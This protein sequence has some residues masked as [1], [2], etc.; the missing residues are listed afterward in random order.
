MGTE[1]GTIGIKPLKLSLYFGTAA[2][3]KEFNGREIKVYITDFL[4]YLSGKLEATEITSK[5][6]LE[7]DRSDGGS[8]EAK[9]TNTITATY[10]DLFTNRKWP[11]DIRKG[12]QVF[13]FNVGDSDTYYWFSLGRD[14]KLR[15]CEKLR[16]EISDD[17][18]FI[19]E[20]TNDNT[21]YVEM[22]TLPDEEGNPVK[23]F[24]ISTAKSD[25]EEFRYL[26][27]IDAIANTLQINDD[28]DNMILMESKEKRIFLRN[29]DGCSLELNKKN[30]AL[31]A[32]DELTLKAGKLIVFDGPLLADQQDTK[33]KA[34]IKIADNIHFTANESFVITTPMLGIRGPKNE[35]T[36]EEEQ[37]NVTICG[38]LLTKMFAA[39][40][41]SMVKF[42]PSACG[43]NPCEE[44]DSEEANN[45]VESLVMRSIA[46]FG[47]ETNTLKSSGP[48]EGNRPEELKEE[49]ADGWGA[50]ELRDDYHFHDSNVPSTSASAYNGVEIDINTASCSETG[51]E[52]NSVDT[53]SGRHLAAWD[54]I[55]S[56]LDRNSVAIQNIREAIDRLAEV[57]LD[58]SDGSNP[59]KQS[60]YMDILN[61]IKQKTEYADKL[62]VEARVLG[63]NSFVKNG[64]TG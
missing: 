9:Q 56:A 32:V 21:W 6:G 4:P 3:D 26:I 60:S 53:E 59:E 38:T 42:D 54:Q 28:A 64:H 44:I 7:D 37:V 47:A 18:Q 62:G 27:R 19:K 30:A 46:M 1:S 40:C 51:N 48:D 45:N 15:R 17:V 10:S 36:G 16:W 39:M 8:G 24:V 57:V 52:K 23:Q 11:P 22:V 58:T 33:D 49:F 13:V 41:T 20:L 55:T 31:V 2:A 29:T 35:D 63:V 34:A 5:V 43:E 12:E 14:D 50:D 61:E 25:G